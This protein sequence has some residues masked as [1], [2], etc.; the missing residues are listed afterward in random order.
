[1]SLKKKDEDEM[2]RW[3]N[4][5]DRQLKGIQP[6]AKL[7]SDATYGENYKEILSWLQNAEN[8]LKE[9]QSISVELRDAR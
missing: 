4:A 2:R 1:M 9:A 3:S 5:L 7:A 8:C 6:N